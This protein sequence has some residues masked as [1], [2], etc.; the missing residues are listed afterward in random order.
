MRV[1]DFF[2]LKI[3]GETIHWC[4]DTIHITIH[5]KRYDTYHDICQL[6]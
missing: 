4:H 5:A 3:R 2:F 6:K 1:G